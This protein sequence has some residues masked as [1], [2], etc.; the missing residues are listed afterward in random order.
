MFST[1]ELIEHSPRAIV[2]LKLRQNVTRGML[3]GQ[4]SV[5][6]FNCQRSDMMRSDLTRGVCIIDASKTLTQ[7]S[8]FQILHFQN[9][10]FKPAKLLKSLFPDEALFSRAK[11]IT[12]YIDPRQNNL[13]QVRTLH[14]LNER[15]R[16]SLNSSHMIQCEQA[17]SAKTS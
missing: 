7:R 13:I 14:I 17:T 15:F 4:G 11:S 9:Q 6:G 8:I 5:V 10:N 2:S 12:Y 16:K 3:I 1:L